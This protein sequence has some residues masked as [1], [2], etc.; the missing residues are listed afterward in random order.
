[1]LSPTPGT[2][3]AEDVLGPL[4]GPSSSAARPPSVPSPT[5]PLAGST[6][7]E[8][9]TTQ[10]V[11]ESADQRNSSASVAEEGPRRFQ[12]TALNVA[13]IAGTLLALV[14]LAASPRV[15]DRWRSR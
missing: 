11:Q 3:T 15:Y 2:T 9:S 6:P 7:A 12:L 8:S 4:A 10:E 13:W 14:L 1:M 5:A